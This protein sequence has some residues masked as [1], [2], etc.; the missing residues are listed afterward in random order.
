M[1]GG[2]RGPGAG[3]GSQRRWRF[4]RAGVFLERGCRLVLLVS[5]KPRLAW[6]FGRSEGLKEN[7]CSEL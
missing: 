3:P 1:G 5:L 2:G 4:F 7:F 6:V